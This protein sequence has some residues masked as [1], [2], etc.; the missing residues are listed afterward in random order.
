[1]VEKP[2]E[3]DVAGK[4]TLASS[5]VRRLNAIHGGD[6]PDSVSTPIAVFVPMD[7]YHL[8]R[9]QLSAMP[10]PV[11]ALAGR[12]AAFTFDVKTFLNLVKKLRDAI[13]PG[14]TTLYA[15]SFDHAIKDPVEN[16]I[17]IPPTARVIIFE[18][19]YLSL[20]KG[21]WKESAAMMDELWFVQ[22][23]FETARRRLVKRHIMAGIAR[24]EMDANKRVTENDLV[25]AKEI[26]DNRLDVQEVVISKED[27]GWR[28]GA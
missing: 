12:G 19:N 22:V 27:E 26:V 21:L 7:G 24:D 1:M 13:L 4:S 5:V 8:S 14:S 18:G 16:D 15:P 2:N 25:N 10:D 20:N 11:K 28:E 23:D 9:A 6:T 17:A 3:H